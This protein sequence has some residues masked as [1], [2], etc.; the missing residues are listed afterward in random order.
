MNINDIYKDFKKLKS[1]SERVT[2][3]EG[4]QKLNLGYDI[5]YDNLIKF[6][7]RRNK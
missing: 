2:F 6:Y 4:L 7:T 5:C 3:L 1:D